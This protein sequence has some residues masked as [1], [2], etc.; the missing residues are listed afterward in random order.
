MGVLSIALLAAALTQDAGAAPADQAVTSYDAGFFAASRPGDAKA[1]IDRIPGF[2]F[3]G[4][5]AVRGLSGAAGNVLI[6]G[7]RPSSKSDS[8]SDVLARIP[9]DQVIRIDVIRG[10]APGIDM[11]RKPVVANVIRDPRGGISGTVTV[12]DTLTLDAEGRNEGEVAAD[13][14]ARLGAHV[15]EAAASYERG[16]AHDRRGTHRVRTAGD[17][18]LLMDSRIDSDKP[19]E[20]VVGSAAYETALPL[21]DVRLNIRGYREITDVTERDAFDYPAGS[22]LLKEAYRGAGG[23]FGG[24]YVAPLGG[25]VELETV[26]LRSWRTNETRATSVTAAKTVGYRRFDESGETVGRAVLR[27]HGWDAL[28]LETGLEAA[29]NWLEGDSALMVGGALVPAPGS[30]AR[31]EERR[32]EG[33]ATGVWQP[34]PMLALEAGLRFEASVLDPGRGEEQGLE[35]AKP[36]AALTWTPNAQQLVRI[37]I[38]REVGQLN[39]NDFVASVNMYTGVVTAGAGMLAPTQTLRTEVAFEQRFAGRGALAAILRHEQIEDVIGLAPVAG[40][41]GLFDARS[42][43]GPG[44]RQMLEVNSTVPLDAG[45]I[46]GGLLKAGLKAVRSEVTDAATG[47]HRSYSGQSA[48]EW[49]AAFTQDLPEWNA[50]WGVNL[51]GF[52]DKTAYRFDG[53]EVSGAEPWASAFVD[54]SPRA[55][56]T[57]RLEVNNLTGRSAWSERDVHAGLRHVADLVYAERRDEESYRNVRLSVRKAFN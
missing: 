24:R 12:S 23:E 6:D 4:G 28:S 8:L 16:D 49:N 56:V 41:N 38:E 32:G 37:R 40:P 2:A 1:M 9:A 45:G 20:E 14:A 19:G 54:Y 42:N 36:S 43:V 53:T 26:A 18:R 47:E 27:F 34:S 55:D 13:L 57:L 22:G 3:D 10:G 25:G 51:S 5:G 11:Q 31:V 30:Q 52:T 39:F 15:F 7:R 35:F 44:L 48:L 17:G 29:F 46:S 21:G 50:T 33:F